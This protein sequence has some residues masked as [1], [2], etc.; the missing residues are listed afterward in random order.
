M[1][2][3]APFIEYD[4]QLI[5]FYSHIYKR[6]IA[7][8]NE[9]LIFFSSFK[10]MCMKPVL[11]ILFFVPLLSTGQKLALIDRN[12]HQ[13]ISIADTIT[14]EEATRGVV[15]VYSKDI[16]SVINTIQWLIK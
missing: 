13:P 2:I 5:L 10:L 12:F 11:L 9:W 8:M 3:I 7:G 4:F 6:I 1:R 14:M 15:P 16:Y